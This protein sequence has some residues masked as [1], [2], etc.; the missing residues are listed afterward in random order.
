MRARLYASPVLLFALLTTAAPA[1][2]QAP[3]APEEAVMEVIDRLFDGMRAGDSTAVRSVFDATARLVTVGEQDGVPMMRD[4]SVDAFVAAVGRPHPQ[5]W[6]ER[7]WDVEIYFDGNLASAWM[8]YA[9]F[10]GDTFSHCGVDSIQLFR[11]AAGWKIIFLADTR[12]QEGCDLP[13]WDE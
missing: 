1:G 2:A 4:G 9:F 5:V 7:I 8:N 12:Q 3:E 11:S 13:D 10:L 6:D